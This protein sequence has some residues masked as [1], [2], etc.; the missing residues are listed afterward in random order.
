MNL[1]SA[2]IWNT[3]ELKPGDEIYGVVNEIRDVETKDGKTATL[4]EVVTD[5][6][7]GVY[8]VWVSG[9]ALSTW[10]RKDKV[11]PGDSVYIRFLE[12]KKL[13]GGK[14]VKTYATATDKSEANGEID[15]FANE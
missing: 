1:E 13:G 9:W 8:G 6:E 11:S 3:D 7:P 10:V 15:P 4:M 5:K 2:P 12:T 14:T